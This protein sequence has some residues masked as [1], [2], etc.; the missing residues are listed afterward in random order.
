MLHMKAASLRW[1]C[2]FNVLMNLA[3]PNS[4]T[5]LRRAPS[6]QVV[7]ASGD[8]LMEGTSVETRPRKGP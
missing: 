2:Y 3:N 7:Q 4:G 1:G 8:P 5:L 6:S